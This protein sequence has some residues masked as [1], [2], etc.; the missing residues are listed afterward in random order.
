MDAASVPCTKAGVVIT[1]AF[2]GV[3]VTTVFWHQ[4]T[5]L[6]WHTHLLRSAHMR[7]CRR[8]LFI[9][10]EGRGWEGWASLCRELVAWRGRLLLTE[11]EISVLSVSSR[12]LTRV[13]VYVGVCVH[14]YCT[15]SIR[16]WAQW[17]GRLRHQEGQKN[18][19]KLN[20]GIYVFVYVYKVHM[21][22]YMLGG[23]M[24]SWTNCFF[25]LTFF[26]FRKIKAKDVNIKPRSPIQAIYTLNTS[27][28]Y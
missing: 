2:A 12:F 15:W 6:L 5:H 28:G 22:T 25:S 21:C 7:S 4:R 3:Y 8:S 17:S 18:P 20:L 19:D 10:V 24:R 26:F 1:S 16:M 13:G 23:G 9:S 11:R 14:T 27:Q